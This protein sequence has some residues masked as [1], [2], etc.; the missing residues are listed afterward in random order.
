MQYSGIYK[1]TFPIKKEILAAG[2]FGAREKTD[3]DS[4]RASDTLLYGNCGKGA[5]FRTSAAFHAG[6]SVGYGYDLPALLKY[7]MRANLH[8]H[9]APRTFLRIELQSDH[10]F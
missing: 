6:I 10:V 7:A 2:G 3:D 8:A 4:R 1:T 9:A 5:V